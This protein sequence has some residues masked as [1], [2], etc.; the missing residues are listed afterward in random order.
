MSHTYE[1][2]MSHTY[3]WVMSHTYEWVMSHTYECPYPYGYGYKCPCQPTHIRTHV[4][5]RVT[6]RVNQLTPTHIWTHVCQRVT[7]RVNQLT[8]THT[9]SH[10]N[11]CLSTSHE[12][13]QPTPTNSHITWLI[14]MCVT[15]LIHTCVT[16]HMYVCVTW[17]M[18]EPCQPTHISHTWVSW[19]GPRTSHVCQR[20][21]YEWVMS[22]MNE[23]WSNVSHATVSTSHVWMSHATHPGLFHMCDMTRSPQQRHISQNP[24]LRPAC[25]RVQRLIYTCVPWLIVMCVTNPAEMRT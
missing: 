17:P 23:S 15:W 21:T 12:P 7:N 18:Y 2:V 19:R 4:C 16:W 24:C 11:S 6:N 8:P 10:T 25:T 1:W 20:V 9:N 14:H 3:E 5:Q 13:C 22:H